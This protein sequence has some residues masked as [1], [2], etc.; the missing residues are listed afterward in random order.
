MLTGHGKIRSYLYRFG[1]TDNVMCTCEEKEQTA[2]RLIFQCKKLH[3]Q[4]NAMKKKKYKNKRGNW[5]TSNETLV[6]NYLNFLQH[7]LNL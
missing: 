5:P 1:L 7:L 2:D 4:I 3:N 6:N